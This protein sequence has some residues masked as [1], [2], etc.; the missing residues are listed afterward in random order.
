MSGGKCLHR[1]DARHDLVRHAGLGKRGGF[2]G[3]VLLPARA[4]I[5]AGKVVYTEGGR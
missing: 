3:G 4:T 2:L 5:V 1:G